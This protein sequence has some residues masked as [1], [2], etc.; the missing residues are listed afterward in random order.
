MRIAGPNGSG[1]ACVVSTAPPAPTEDASVEPRPPFQLCRLIPRQ[2]DAPW[3]LCDVGTPFG[4]PQL[5]R[6]PRHRRLRCPP[7]NPDHR[8]DGRDCSRPQSSRWSSGRC[9]AADHPRPPPRVNPRS[10]PR[11]RPGTTWPRRSA[12]ALR[13]EGARCPRRPVGP[14]EDL[15]RHR[16]RPRQAPI[17]GVQDPNTVIGP[18]WRRST[19]RSEVRRRGARYAPNSMRSSSPATSARVT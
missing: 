5:H 6:N 10:H 12:P 11:R 3:V 13:P 19:G 7:V 1:L 15:P 18:S 16:R 2:F 8:R 4:R 9:H 14:V 17:A